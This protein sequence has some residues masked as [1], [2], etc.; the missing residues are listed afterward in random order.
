[1]SVSAPR[2]K[3]A[4][5]RKVGDVG[6]SAASSEAQDAPGGEMKRMTPRRGEGPYSMVRLER[7]VTQ[8]VDGQNALLERIDALEEALAHRERRVAELEARLKTGEE[9]RARAIE[10]IDHLI[11]Q[12]DELEGRAESAAFSQAGASI[13]Q[14]GAMPPSNEPTQ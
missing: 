7:A 8:L 11:D 3:R 12:L 6:S 1:M 14:A 13:S 5:D 10:R 9:R 2:S 4:R